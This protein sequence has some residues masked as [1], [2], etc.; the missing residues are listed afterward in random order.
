MCFNSSYFK[1]IVKSSLNKENGMEI[2]EKILVKK[3]D[4]FLEK[5]TYRDDIEQ[6][7]QYIYQKIIQNSNITWKGTE[8]SYVYYIE[9]MDMNYSK[10]S[11]FYFFSLKDDK[12][13]NDKL[14]KLINLWA[15]KEHPLSQLL[16]ATAK[17]ELY[18]ALDKKA[19][20]ELFVSQNID[21][22]VATDIFF[23]QK[24]SSIFF[25]N[26]ETI[27][28]ELFIACKK[29][30]DFITKDDSSEVQSYILNK[31]QENH[32]KRLTN[33]N[34]ESNITISKKYFYSIRKN[35]RRQ[36]Y[37]SDLIEIWAKENSLVYS[38]NEE[39]KKENFKRQKEKSYIDIKPI[40][41]YDYFSKK[42][43]TKPHICTL[44]TEWAKRSAFLNI[45]I[46]NLR[47]SYFL[48]LKIKGSLLLEIT[49]YIVDDHL[50]PNKKL[51]DKNK[52]YFLRKEDLEN[53][54]QVI[55]S[56]FKGSETKYLPLLYK[57]NLDE[58]IKE[59]RDS[60]KK[61]P[62]FLSMILQYKIYSSIR[63]LTKRIKNNTLT[64]K[65]K[66]YILYLNFKNQPSQYIL[67]KIETS[68]KEIKKILDNTILEIG[69]EL[70][71]FDF[72]D[73][74]YGE[75]SYIHNIGIDKE[76]VLDKY[77]HSN[78]LE[79]IIDEEDDERIAKKGVSILKKTLST[80]EIIRLKRYY[81]DSKNM[82][83]EEK[84]IY[85]E[86]LARRGNMTVKKFRKD[87]AKNVYAVTKNFIAEFNTFYEIASVT[88]Q[89]YVGS[90]IKTIY[91]DKIKKDIPLRKKFVNMIL[92]Y[93]GILFDF[94]FI[95]Q[96]KRT[97]KEE[98]ELFNTLLSEKTE[99]NE[100]RKER[101]GTL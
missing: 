101:N 69:K 82:R 19:N 29:K 62:S 68:Y 97:L 73:S 66:D 64:K 24:I 32:Y 72:I 27:F 91:T 85:L 90:F 5:Y 14:F 54:S 9:E 28:Y 10:E 89:V 42:I 94:F 65:E 100:I 93:N 96:N 76:E 55:N 11:E 41:V 13:K 26:K 52:N 63:E 20:K 1:I 34:P 8:K 3:I 12:Y 43:E 53:V 31:L 98:R 25:S 4:I 16:E 2:T 22:W 84:K 56:F 21:D 44:F 67:E 74:K 39:L 33:Y 86:R 57:Y 7:K 35:P 77:S 40:T 51:T 46:Q 70:I 48:S 59:L 47:K 37:I 50:S 80:K 38:L 79:N 17:K 95:L 78:S 58:L 6:Q 61:L 36:E 87:I 18:K 30:I 45:I 92:D 71:K 15:N 83:T 81:Q 60:N 23:N 88:K 75:S 99:I 49:Q